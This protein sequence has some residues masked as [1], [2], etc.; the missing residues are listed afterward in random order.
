[1]AKITK[2][3]ILRTADVARL[4][5]TDEEATKYSEQISS[6]LTFTEKINDINTDDVEPTTNGNKIIDVMRKDEQVQYIT[7]EAALKNAPEHEAGQFVVPQIM[8]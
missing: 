7:K 8:D 4:G 3:D 2:D 5:I 1:M 6:I